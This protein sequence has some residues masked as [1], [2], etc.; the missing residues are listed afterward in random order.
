MSE[1]EKR[2]AEQ[3]LDADPEES[4]AA[5]PKDPA[6]KKSLDYVFKIAPAD[7]K[8]AFNFED[9]ADK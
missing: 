9:V 6:Q 7:P 3:P 5:K 8:N 1:Q 4:K 2:S